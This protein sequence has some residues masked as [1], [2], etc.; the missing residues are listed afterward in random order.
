MRKCI[1]ILFLNLLGL[2]ACSK[3]ESIEDNNNNTQSPPPKT[4]SK[5]IKVE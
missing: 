5:A 3:S 1:Y 2:Y 4:E